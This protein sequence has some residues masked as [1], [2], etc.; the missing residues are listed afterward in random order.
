[1]SEKHP[2][3]GK[4]IEPR[5]ERVA[6]LLCEFARR[7]PDE[8]EPGNTP[9]DDETEV[10]DGRLN[11]RPAFYAWRLFVSRAKKIVDVLDEMTAAGTGRG[12]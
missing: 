9:Y 12:S 3:Y 1:M 10:I 7:N 6:R 5:V 4:N 8:L 2:T 11:E